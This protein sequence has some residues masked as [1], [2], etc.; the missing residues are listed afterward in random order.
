MFKVLGDAQNNKEQEI[1]CTKLNNTNSSN[2]SNNSWI[3]KVSEPY[4]YK[5]KWLRID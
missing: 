1:W 5:Y 4:T 2:G 3:I